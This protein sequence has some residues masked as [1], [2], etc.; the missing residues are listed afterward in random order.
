MLAIVATLRWWGGADVARFMT[1][2]SDWWREPWRLLAPVLFHANLV[3]LLFNL[4]WLWAFGTRVEREFG[5]VRALGIFLLLALGANAAEQAVFCGNVGL[6]GLVS[7]LFGLLLVLGRKDARF[8]DAADRQ[9]AQ[10]LLAWFILCIV[11]SIAQVWRAAN[12]ANGAGFVLGAAL[13]WTIVARPIGRQLRRA[14]VLAILFILFAAAGTVARSYLSFSGD[15]G[16]ELSEQGF[17]AIE[18]GQFEKA[19]SL[20]E[21]AL[22]TDPNAR[23]WSRNLGMAYEMV[24]RNDDAMLAYQRSDALN[25]TDLCVPDFLLRQNHLVHWR[26]HP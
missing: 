19:V 8:T 21:R 12:L 24:G 6:F 5:H 13:G 15:L 11:L 26:P 23:G 16:R 14:A 3:C 7:G 10:L 1:G 20:Y 25:P 4:Y 18:H 9:T 22:D 17:T 2:T